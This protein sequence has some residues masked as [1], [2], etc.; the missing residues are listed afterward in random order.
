MLSLSVFFLR[1]HLSLKFFGKDRQAACAGGD[2]S[3]LIVEI[4][5]GQT[6]FPNF[7]NYFSMFMAVFWILL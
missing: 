3:K 1:F 6:A 2:C 4:G 5:V 7:G